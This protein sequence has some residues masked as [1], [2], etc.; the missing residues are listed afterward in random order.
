MS[1]IFAVSSGVPPAAI[2]VMRISGTLAVETARLLCGSLP[3]PR[4]AALRAV[5]HPGSGDL[6][7][8]ALVLCF[9][10][11]ASATGEDLVELH[12][13]G[14]R[15]IVA[16]VSAVLGS[17]P[18]LR[19]A[20]PGEFTRRALASGR[21]D[22]A[23]AEGLGDLLAAETETQ[24]RR[25][26]A[27]AE[28]A[29]SRA[30]ANFSHRL[31]NV[32][33]AVEAVLDFGDEDDVAGADSMSAIR[34]TI[35][36]LAADIGDLVSQPTVERLRDGVR[37]VLAGPRNAGKSTLIN[38]LAGRDVAIVSPVGGTTRDRIEVPVARDGIAYVL[39]DTAGLAAESN[40][41]VERIGID[42]ARQAIDTADILIWLDDHAPP[43]AKQ[44]IWLYPRADARP[45]L[46][47]PDRLAISVHEGVGLGALWE[48]LA[49]GARAVL[50][51]E[52][53]MA[54]NMRQRDLLAEC[55]LALQ[56]ASTHEDLLII[57]EQLRIARGALD[58][59]TGAT[60]VELMLDAL[61][62]RFCIG[63]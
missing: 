14:G 36:G 59:I 21:I 24:R 19:A 20:E 11:P 27:M 25:A 6:L 16:A 17:L 49:A 35:H 57:A 61:F 48:Q 22:L 33:A 56:H 40:D 4:M 37:V 23:E 30:V 43:A 53:K 51:R 60:D 5:R 15:A 3:P 44:V 12:L 50:P 62:G 34:A 2:A 38:A 28:G 1:T 42:L 52:D 45:P 29:V 7:D 32:S 26:L 13:H 41:Q 54:V 8:R 39:T 63:K 10:G 47:N 9:P 55:Q 31:L 18:G 46:M 58:R